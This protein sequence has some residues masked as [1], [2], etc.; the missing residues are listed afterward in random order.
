MSEEIGERY[1]HIPAQP[2]SREIKNSMGQA[3]FWY[4]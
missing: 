1:E 2:G 3:K 4:C